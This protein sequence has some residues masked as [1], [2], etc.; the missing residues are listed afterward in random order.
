[1]PSGLASCHGRSCLTSQT[2]VRSDDRMKASQPQE[3]GHVIDDDH[4]LCLLVSRL[5]MITVA[6]A[7]REGGSTQTP[8]HRRMLSRM[9]ASIPSYLRRETGKHGEP[10]LGKGLERSRAGCGARTHFH[11]MLSCLLDRLRLLEYCLDSCFVACCLDDWEIEENSSHDLVRSGGGLARQ[12]DARQSTKDHQPLTLSQ[13][14]RN[15][16]KSD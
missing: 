6:K 10:V 8:S 7:Y 13:E 15:G 14:R 2:L 4:H 16:L 3:S 5:D 12:R 1:M 11:D 9:A